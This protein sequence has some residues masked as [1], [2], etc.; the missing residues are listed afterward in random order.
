MALR[1]TVAVL[2]ACVLFPFTLRDTLLRAAADGL[3]ELRWSSTILDEM[4]RSLVASGTMARGKAARLRA[5]MER[6][7]PESSVAGFEPLLRRMANHPG[8]RH[9]VA[10][11]AKCKAGLVVTSN[12]RHFERL[13]RGISAVSPDEFLGGLVSGFPERMREILVQQAADLDRP[14]VTFAELVDRLAR[15]V[16]DFARRVRAN[17]VSKTGADR[18]R[19]R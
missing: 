1:H 16:P 17:E 13:P 6:S 18:G 11:A 15:A 19:E 4:E 5:V 3:Y 14:P 2:D 9:V 7:F 10:A 12:L 8:D